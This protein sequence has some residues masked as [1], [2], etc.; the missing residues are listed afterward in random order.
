MAAKTKGRKKGCTK[1]GISARSQNIPADIVEYV[2]SLIGSLT[3]PEITKPTFS[4]V[5]VAAIR[6]GLPTV[7]KQ[8]RSN[9]PAT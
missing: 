7:A 2:E 6:E 8:C 5:I 9:E 3:G 1:A 4:G